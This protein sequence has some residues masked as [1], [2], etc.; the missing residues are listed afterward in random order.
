MCELC[1]RSHRWNSCGWN[2]W[3]HPN[4]VARPGSDRVNRASFVL[5]TTAAVN[6]SSVT[7]L[8]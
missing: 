1:R 3:R 4:A 5:G 7:V 2:C 8:S 6:L